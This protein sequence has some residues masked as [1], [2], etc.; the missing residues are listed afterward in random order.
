MEERAINKK[1]TSTLSPESAQIY[2]YKLKSHSFQ[3]R[4][5]FHHTY[6]ELSFKTDRFV[7]ALKKSAAVCK[8]Q[9]EKVEIIE[10]CIAQF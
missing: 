9:A 7:E 6:F 3:F 5:T 4:Y 10:L 2:F 8:I 1:L